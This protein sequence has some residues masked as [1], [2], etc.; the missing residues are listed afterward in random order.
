MQ[1]KWSEYKEYRDTRFDEPKKK[2]R[3]RKVYVLIE[4]DP[5]FCETCP[6]VVGAFTS[7]KKC[8][9]FAKSLPHSA[10]WYTV[11]EYD[12]ST[13]KY[14]KDYQPYDDGPIVGSVL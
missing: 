11:E 4:E 1:E 5:C 13:G 8:V 12:A 3:I 7:K 6:E 9:Q 14:I 10:T 2:V